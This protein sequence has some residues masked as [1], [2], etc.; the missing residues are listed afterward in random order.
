MDILWMFLLGVSL[1]A[2]ITMMIDMG[3]QKAY[4]LGRRAGYAR[5]ISDSR[6]HASQ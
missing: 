5:A 4:W 1:T 6:D 3:M 2:I